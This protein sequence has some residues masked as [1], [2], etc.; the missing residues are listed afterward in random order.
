MLNNAAKYTEDN[1]EIL[2]N[3]FARNGSA[4]IEVADN[5]IGMD[6]VLLSHVFDLFTQAERTPDRSLGGLGIGLALVKTMIS[7]HGGEVT[8]VSE[9]LGLGSKFTVSLPLVR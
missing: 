6:A 9:E 2:V 1:G 3:V 4:F 8:A 7:L 5:G